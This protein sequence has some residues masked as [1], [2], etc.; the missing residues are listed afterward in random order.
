MFKTVAVSALAMLAVAG[1]AKA[2]DIA[3]PPE[4]ESG[5]Q[6]EVAPY[7]W[8]AG[9]D[10]K[11]AQFGLP[12]QDVDI[13]IRQVLENLDI[14]LM[15]LV[16]VRNERFSA[17]SDLVYGKLTAEIGT[18]HGILADKVEITSTTVMWTVGAA[19]SIYYDPDVANF[20]LVVGG[21]LWSLDTDVKIKGLSP[22]IDIPTNFSDGQTWV[23][24]LVGAKGRVSLSPDFFLTGWGLIGGFGITDDKLMW[25]LF[26]G[27]GYEFMPGTSVIA[28]YR[29]VS[30]D[31]EKG[32]FLYDT[33]QQGPLLGVDFRF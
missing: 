29:A 9:L 32:S 28:G 21:R 8:L 20:D 12:E 31:Y 4:V 26:G 33:V 17:F 3:P 10:G 6:F 23:D 22:N 25:D 1:M 5:W 27:V 14:A 15:G 24:P 19:Y 11:A 30:V 2:A 13:S 18:P 16:Q 7:G